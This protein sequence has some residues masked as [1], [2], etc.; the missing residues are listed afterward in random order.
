M[1]FHHHGFVTVGDGAE[2]SVKRGRARDSLYLRADLKFDDEP[3][4]REVR[5]RNLSV[6]GMMAE[7]DRVVPSGTPVSVTVRGIGEVAG[8]VAWCAE[9]R[10]GISFDVQIDPKKARK[11]IGKRA[12]TS[13]YAKAVPARG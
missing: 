5:V 12:S 10:A 13:D 11:P 8:R 9:G 2:G 4:I 6:G 3:R 7:L 1:T